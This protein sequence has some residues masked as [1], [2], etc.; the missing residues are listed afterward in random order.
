MRG[1][2]LAVWLTLLLAIGCGDGGNPSPAGSGGAGA[3]AG[4]GATGGVQA[5]SGATAGSTSGSSSGG[6]GSGSGTGGSAGS[7]ADTL[8][9]LPKAD[10][11]MPGEYILTDDAVCNSALPRGIPAPEAPVFSFESIALRTPM[12]PGKPYS[13]SVESK[14]RK[15]MPAEWSQ[16]IYGAM[17]KCGTG[18]ETADL[19]DEKALDRGPF[20]YC[21]TLM[22]T[23]AY[24]HIIVATRLVSDEGVLARG[25][26]GLCPDV[27]CPTR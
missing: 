18:G 1:T 11:C 25:G 17:S 24:T 15:A 20:T 21:S 7:S 16:E 9:G 6:A 4:S 14:I 26:Y 8:G 12:T 2:R 19:L 27:M 5:G 10:L 3:G 13:V 23:K 22:P